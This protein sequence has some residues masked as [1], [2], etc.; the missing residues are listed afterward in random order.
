MDLEHRNVPLIKQVA[1]GVER[2]INNALR[3]Q[4]VTYSQIQL[5]LRLSETESGSMPFKALEE[6][7]GVSQAAVARLVKFLASKGYLTV[8][9]DPNDRRVKHAHIAP[10]GKSKC[11]EAHEHMDS[12]ER[13]LGLTTVE[14]HLLYELL[15]KVRQNL[16]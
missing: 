14:A 6:K 10:L 4:N 3:Q 9:E 12:I 2:E 1:D 16:K 15:S 11:D 8:S 7:L 5:L 13:A